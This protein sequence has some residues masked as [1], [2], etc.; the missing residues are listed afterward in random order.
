MF[1]GFDAM[2]SPKSK[3]RGDVNGEIFPRKAVQMIANHEEAATGVCRI[4]NVPSE[5]EEILVGNR[6]KSLSDLGFD[7]I[8]SL[9][10]LIVN[11]ANG[12]DQTCFWLYAGVSDMDSSGECPW[13]CKGY[14][15]DAAQDG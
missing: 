15:T 2:P 8:R 5:M 13:I 9:R 10:V 3:K 4:C 7:L 12:R 1:P 14:F 11:E 6:R